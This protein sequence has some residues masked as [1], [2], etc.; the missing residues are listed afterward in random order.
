[1]AEIG[2]HTVL[3]KPPQSVSMVIGLRAPMPKSR[4]S[5]E[6]AAS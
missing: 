4:P 6:Y 2:Q 3:A 1:M 5:V